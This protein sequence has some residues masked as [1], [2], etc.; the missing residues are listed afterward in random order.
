MPRHR[1]SRGQCLLA[2]GALG[3]LTMGLQ[4]P[5]PLNAQSSSNATYTAAQASA[6]KTAYSQSCAGCHGPN[7]DDGE[8]APPLKGAA[9]IQKYAGKPVDELIGYIT[10]KMPPG[11]PGRLGAAVYTQ[12]AAFILQQNDAPAGAVDLPADATQLA[13]LMFPVQR[14]CGPGAG[15]RE[16][17]APFLNTPIRFDSRA[18]IPRSQRRIFFSLWEL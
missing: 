17:D 4:I 5:G 12:I 6:G 9:F 14:G 16:P 7:T 8:F 10:G 1:I 15:C 3:A 2:A 11:S 18:P 13:R